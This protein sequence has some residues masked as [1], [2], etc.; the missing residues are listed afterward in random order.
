MRRGG[1]GSP[2]PRMVRCHICLGRYAIGSLARHI[3]GCETKAV[4]QMEEALPPTLRC[5]IVQVEHPVPKADDS[6]AAFDTYNKAAERAYQ[7]SMPSCPQCS[8]KFQPDRL[9]KH[10]QKCC[11]GR[12][13]S[14]AAAI[15][16]QY[17]AHTQG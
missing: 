4:R 7:A 1:E 6:Q 14:T 15:S 2:A 17:G 16:E 8:C 13:Q 10:M 11:L 9:L 5:S 3:P 12:L